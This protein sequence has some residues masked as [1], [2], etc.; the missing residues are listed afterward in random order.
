MFL[1][2]ENPGKLK[3]TSLLPLITESAKPDSLHLNK[4]QQSKFRIV[5]FKVISLANPLSFFLVIFL[6]RIK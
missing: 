4:K 5:K 3:H 2:H 1:N 6:M